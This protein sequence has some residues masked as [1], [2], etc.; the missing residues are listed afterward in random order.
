MAAVKRE[1][2][3][4]YADLS[5]TATPDFNQIDQGFN[6]F[7]ETL[8]PETKQKQYIGEATA[9]TV[10]SKFAPNIAYSMNIEHDD[11]VVSKIFGIHKSQ[12]RGTEIT[13]VHVF[14]FDTAVATGFPAIKRVYQVLPDT[15]AFQGEGG[16]EI[17]LSGNLSQKPNSEILGHF[18]VETKV[19]TPEA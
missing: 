14:T 6:T 7:D 1:G 11:P 3:L 4:H 13:I 19:F 5:A 9:Q 10:V 12:T 15:G 8:N 16:A 2:I 17:E 18:D